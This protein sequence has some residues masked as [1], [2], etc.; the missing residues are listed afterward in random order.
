MYI[1]KSH[2]SGAKIFSSTDASCTGKRDPKENIGKS[3]I[4]AQLFSL[5][6]CISG[7]FT[8]VTHIYSYFSTTAF[9][10][11]PK[12]Y[13]LVTQCEDLGVELDLHLTYI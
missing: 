8:Y 3:Y 11:Y 10:Q 13:I 5:E 12:K 1:S 9:P 7:L 6:H 4:I 2:C